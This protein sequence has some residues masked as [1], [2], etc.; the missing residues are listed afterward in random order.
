MS[1]AA[2]ILLGLVACELLAGAAAI[3]VKLSTPQPPLAD[4]SLVDR[5][6]AEEIRLLASAASTPE[7]WRRLGETYMATGF[8]REAEACHRVAAARQP[9]DGETVHQWAFALERLGALEEA[10]AAYARAAQVDPARA[11]YSMYYIAR[12]KLRQEDLSAAQDALAKAGDLP[13]GRYEMARLLVRQG[14]RDEA[15]QILT[16]LAREFP[17]AQQP[18]LVQY[19]LA[20]ANQQPAE[21]RD[22]ADRQDAARARVPSPFDVEFERLRSRHDQFGRKG[23]WRQAYRLLEEGNAAAA[24]RVL[25]ESLAANYDE[26]PA[27][28]LAEALFQQGRVEEAMRVQQE[29]LQRL[30][31]KVEY[32]ERLGDTLNALGRQEEARAAWQRATQ[33]SFGPPLRDVHGKLAASLAAAG[34]EEQATQEFALTAQAAGIAEFRAG[35]LTEAGT[36]LREAVRLDPQLAH[37]WYYLGETARQQG[38]PAGAQDAY[39]RCLATQTHHGR[40]ADRLDQLG[41]QPKRTNQPE[42]A[43]P[44]SPSGPSG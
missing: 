1:R 30:G 37:A 14:E 17:R 10:N 23:K 44:P 39:E 28:L 29:L 35:R 42:A 13:I 26:Y 25:R 41:P 6:T 43:T 27:D 19:Q 40:A 5:I 11:A 8:F 32:L 3:G 20:L 15:A 16:E 9:N 38:D 7:D 31:P 4:L 24:E 34:L 18:P 36:A 21:A 22:A 2:R 12:N 33:L